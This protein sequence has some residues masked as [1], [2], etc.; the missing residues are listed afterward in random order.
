MKDALD[1][2]RHSVNLPVTYAEVAAAATRIKG[3]A[4]RTPVL[5]SATAD[6]LTGASLFF[7]PENLQRM[8]AFKFRGA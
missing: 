4:H 2:E 7:K 1:D 3:A 5:T 6:A 8:G